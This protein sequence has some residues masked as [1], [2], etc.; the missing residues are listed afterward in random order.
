MASSGGSRV[1]GSSLLIREGNKVAM[2][3]AVLS[4]NVDLSDLA[5][6][7][8]VTH[9]GAYECTRLIGHALEKTHVGRLQHRRVSD[10]ASRD[11]QEVQCGRR[12]LGWLLH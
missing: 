4:T 2:L 7:S 12:V 6:S 5:N 11:D 8:L 1:T 10:E 9:F 3:G